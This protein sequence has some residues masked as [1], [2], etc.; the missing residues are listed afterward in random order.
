MS[1]ALAVTS[2]AVFN[3]ILMFMLRDGDRL[4]RQAL[5]V[6]NGALQADITKLPRCGHL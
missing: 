4:L 2:S 1:A 6:G 5:G 3:R